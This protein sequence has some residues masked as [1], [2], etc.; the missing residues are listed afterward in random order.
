MLMNQIEALESQRPH[1]AATAYEGELA[2]LQTALA[3]KDEAI[4]S[5]ADASFYFYD[6]KRTGR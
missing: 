5:V 2:Q 6:E 4:K 1:R 3:A